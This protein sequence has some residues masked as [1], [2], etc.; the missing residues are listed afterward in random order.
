MSRKQ[1]ASTIQSLL[2]GFL[3][4]ALSTPACAGTGGLPSDG[5]LPNEA[6]S[7]LDEY[8]RKYAGIIADDPNFSYTITSA[9]RAADPN[10]FL[11]DKYDEGWCIVID[12]PM[13]AHSRFLVRRQN[14][15]WVVW[16]VRRLSIDEPTFR[17]VGCSN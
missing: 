13:G 6:E 5:G 17:K 16:D 11:S 15:Q 12:P 1:R 3:I 14:L 10:I 2:L 4:V 8:I 9:Q 7:A